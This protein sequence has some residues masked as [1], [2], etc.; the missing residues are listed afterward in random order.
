MEFPGTAVYG[1]VEQLLN[2][3][4]ARSST[5]RALAASLEGRT[6]EIRTDGVD[7]GLRLGVAAGRIQ[8]G[9]CTDPPADV[10]L[11]G[12]PLALARLLGGEGQALVRERVV[13]L[14]GDAELAERFH[15]LLRATRPDLEEELSGV[16]GDALAGEIGHRARQFADLGARALRS[17]GRSTSEFLREERPVLVSADELREFCAGVDDAANAVARLEARVAR[18]ALVGAG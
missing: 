18:L 13:R 4:L 17:L 5:A 8:A 3:G 14:T 2:R 9:P 15:E 16:V 1:P 7:L 10:T 12:P 6:L 11:A